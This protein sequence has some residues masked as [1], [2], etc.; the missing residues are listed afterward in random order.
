MI[1]ALKAMAIGLPLLAATL[2]A[3]PGTA[4]ADAKDCPGDYFCA[5]TND[6]FTGAMVK[7]NTDSAWWGT[8][9]DNAES[10]Y[11]HRASSATR[12]DNVQTYHDINYGRPGVCVN[13]GETYD[14]A[15]SDNSYSSHE[16][17]NTC[18]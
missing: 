13:P 16:W 6:G 12:K 9:S 2:V 1:K 3:A 11:N 14:A 17:V 8:M 15:M 4:N 18:V 10:I 5:W 7:W